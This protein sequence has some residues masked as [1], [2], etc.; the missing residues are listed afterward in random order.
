MSTPI[1]PSKIAGMGFGLLRF[2]QPEAP[3]CSML[4][5]LSV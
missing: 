5:A 1:M 2:S 4:Y 3:E